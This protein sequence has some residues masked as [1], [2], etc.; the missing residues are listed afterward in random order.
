MLTHCR[1]SRDRTELAG[2]SK[3]ARTEISDDDSPGAV[4]TIFTVSTFVFHNS[5]WTQIA[6]FSGASFGF[7]FTHLTM[8]ELASSCTLKPTTVSF[9][10][11][12]AFPIRC[13]LPPVLSQVDYIH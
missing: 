13:N 11:E 9:P 5:R 4:L 10:R 8:R 3:M 1:T 12:Y 2:E 6:A 7:V